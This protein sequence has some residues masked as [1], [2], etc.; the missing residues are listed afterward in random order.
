MKS[1]FTYYVRVFKSGKV[2]S[3]WGRGLH[4]LDPV[5]GNVLDR[6]SFLKKIIV[7]STRKF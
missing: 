4:P 5:M 3:L 2:F 6:L 7:L 1:L